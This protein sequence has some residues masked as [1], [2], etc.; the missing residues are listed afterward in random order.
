MDALTEF[1]KTKCA[2]LTEE[3]EALREVLRE[4]RQILADKGENDER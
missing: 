3:V 1:Y 4:L 2:L